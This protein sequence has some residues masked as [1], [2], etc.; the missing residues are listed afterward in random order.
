LPPN[1]QAVEVALLAKGRF[2]AH[3]V[4]PDG[5]F[6]VFD[7]TGRVL[8]KLGPPPPEIEG[9]P[10]SVRAQAY[11]GAFTLRGD[12][13]RI[14]LALRHGGEAKIFDSLGRLLRVVETPFT[15]PPNFGV[16]DTRAGP[17][18]RLG[19]DTRMGYLAL[20][21]SA[22]YVFAL[23]SGRTIGGFPQ[24]EYYGDY[25]HVFTWDGK[26]HAVLRLQVEALYI[27]VDEGGTALY[28]SSHDPQPAVYEYPLALPLPK[29]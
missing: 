26:L 13:S 4:L 17:W 3:A 21:S 27:A 7:T 6:L 29:R 10:A 24:R 11:R 12:G 5:Q 9:V 19:A 1:V 18:L 14:A 16:K 22:D 20:A 23:F 28:A 15:F 8:E 2:I 25:V